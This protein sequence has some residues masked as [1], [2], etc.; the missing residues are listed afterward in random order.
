MPVLHK[1]GHAA[2]TINHHRRSSKKC[3]H[4]IPKVRKTAA[5]LADLP[6]HENPLNALLCSSSSGSDMEEE[7]EMEEEEAALDYLVELPET[8]A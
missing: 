7:E 8:A 1:P 2:E 6:G 5:E 3:P 4:H